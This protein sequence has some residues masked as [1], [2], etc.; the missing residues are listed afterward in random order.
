MDALYG[1][2]VETTIGGYAMRMRTTGAVVVA[3]TMVAFSGC[4]QD[5]NTEYFEQERARSEA[6]QKQLRDRVR[7]SQIDAIRPAHN[8]E[9]S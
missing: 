3:A 2:T 9:G 5:G 7:Q 4:T 1:V 6:L 8:N